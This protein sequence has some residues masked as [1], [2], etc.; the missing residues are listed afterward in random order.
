MLD[1]KEIALKSSDC[2]SNPKSWITWTLLT[3]FLNIIHSSVGTP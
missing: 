2:G 1:S 3:F